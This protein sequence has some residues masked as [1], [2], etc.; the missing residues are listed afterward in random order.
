MHGFESVKPR[1]TIDNSHLTRNVA[2][3]GAEKEQ[4]TI[5]DL[6]N[7]SVSLER[8]S[9]GD[10]SDEIRV[11]T[12][13]AIHSLSTGDRTRSDNVEADTERSVLD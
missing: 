13:E 10:G 7:L 4:T 12:N 11:G 5:R 2:R 3:S 9:L 1:T 6:G 8:N